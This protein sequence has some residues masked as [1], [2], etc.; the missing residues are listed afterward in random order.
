MVE[1]EGY[2]QANPLMPQVEALLAHE[3]ADHVE[4]KQRAA[5]LLG[6]TKPTLYTRLRGFG[7]LG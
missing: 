5:S 2:S 6:I 1:M 7:K 4:N 3:M